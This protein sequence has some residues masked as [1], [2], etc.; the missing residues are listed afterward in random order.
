MSEPLF[1][2]LRNT[3]E[4]FCGLST[5]LRIVR[6]R[7]VFAELSRCEK[8]DFRAVKIA[9]SKINPSGN[10]NHG[11]WRSAINYHPM[12]AGRGL[13]LYVDDSAVL[14]FSAAARPDRNAPRL[15]G[16]QMLPLL[17]QS[18]ALN[19]IRLLGPP[20]RLRVLRNAN[21]ESGNH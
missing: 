13:P 20:R 16:R 8:P 14:I 9:Q 11:I 5:G 15:L 21:V 18:L 7:R 10:K 2:L 3:R 1:L 19:P 4:N 17:E 12:R 6:S